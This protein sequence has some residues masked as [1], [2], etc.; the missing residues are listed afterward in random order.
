MSSND[1]DK[2]KRCGAI[3]W[4]AISRS[5][6]SHNP[7]FDARYKACVNLLSELFFIN[8]NLSVLDIG[9]GDGTLFYYLK[10]AFP[11]SILAGI[12]SSKDGIDLAKTYLKKYSIE[13][14]ELSVVDSNSLVHS[15]INYDIVISLDVIE[16]VHDANL[17]LSSLRNRTKHDGH[18]LISTPVRI[19]EF[20]S[21]YHTKE[22]FPQEFKVMIENAGFEV[23]KHIK[24][25]P[26]YY[27]IRYFTATKFIFGKSKTYKRLY[28]FLNIFFN[29]NI[30]L[31]KAP[32]ASYELHESQLILAKINE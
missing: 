30:F 19:N 24:I 31:K 23:I 27:L 15:S 26:M 7:F 5:I 12:D 22:Y 1:F 16:H 29:Y 9:C 13:N 32:A 21:K 18:M 6:N 4:T 10:K 17:F 25:I 8:K 11:D 20:S 28:N 14:V 3:H 2:Y